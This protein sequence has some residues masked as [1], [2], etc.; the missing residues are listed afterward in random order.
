MTS[1]TSRGL[2]EFQGNSGLRDVSRAFKG[3]PEILG[4]WRSQGV[5]GEYQKIS[6]AFQAVRTG[7][8]R[9]LGISRGL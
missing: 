4:A 1:G 2:K 7:L 6:E 8:R 3:V 5:S 9:V